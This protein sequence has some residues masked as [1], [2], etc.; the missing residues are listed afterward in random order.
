M[1]LEILP[2]ARRDINEAADYYLRQR[3]GLEDEFLAELSAAVKMIGARPQQFE[4]VRSGI[5][6]CLLDRF[7]YGVYYRVLGFDMVQIVVVKHHSRRAGFG[8]R[9]EWGDDAASFF[10]RYRGA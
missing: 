3:A 4:Q 1:N 10:C 9:R 5:R 2:L 6:R 8:M 7:P